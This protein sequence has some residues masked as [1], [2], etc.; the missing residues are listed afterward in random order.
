M[1]LVVNDAAFTPYHRGRTVRDA[2]DKPFISWDGEGITPDGEAQQN[3]VLFGNSA[4]YTMSAELPHRPRLLTVDCLAL[5]I[6]TERDNP[7]ALHVGFAFGYDVE[8]ILRDLSIKHLRILKAKGYVLW[9]GYRLEYKRGKWF[10]V[11]KRVGDTKVTA[12]IWDVWGFF[13]CSFVQALKENIGEIP[14]LPEIEAGKSGRK[15][16]TYDDLS[17]GFMVNYWKLELRLTVDMMNALR[18]RLYD[19]GL[20][21]RQWHGPGAIA[22]YALRDRKIGAYMNRELPPEV[23]EAAQYAYAGGRFELFRIGHHAAPVYAYD[24]R[25]AYPSGIREL[26]SLVGGT[27]RHVVNPDPQKLARFGVYHLRFANNSLLTPRPMPYFYRDSRYAIHFPNVVEGWYWTPE[28]SYAQFLGSDVE[29][30][31]GWEYEEDGSRPFAWVEEIYET[32]AEW[33]RNGNASQMAL[34]LLLNSL[35]GKMAQRVGWEA[36]GGPPKWH[37]LEWSGYVTSHARAKLFRAM[38][39]AYGRNSLIGVET[40]GIFSSE[41]LPLDIGTSL[42][43]W[44]EDKYDAMIYLQSGFYFKK[45]GDEWTAKYR[46]FDKG[47]VNQADALSVLRGWTPWEDKQRGVITGTTTRFATMGMYL[48]SP[49]ADELRNRWSTLPRELSIGGDGKRIHR[50]QFCPQCAMEIS[51]A[52]EMHTTSI[53]FPVP[54]DGGHS[55]PH[56]LPWLH[57]KDPNEYRKDEH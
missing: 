1:D 49:F 8:M 40:D 21:I 45:Q 9:H 38:L 25:S 7:H 56:S 57:V 19:A 17:S 13:Q 43:Q 28:A 6:Q 42:G 26:P 14:E 39:L 34:K 46:G 32:R 33:K 48:Q 36:A 51:P 47:S 53:T 20:V 4:G 27:W 44:E 35:Y 22:S 15:Q 37:Q 16:F 23:N 31:E 11:T 55:L 30:I 54:T 29:L 50:V 2:L 10:Q 18:T 52:D 12:R 3:Y 5:I 41:P 24:I